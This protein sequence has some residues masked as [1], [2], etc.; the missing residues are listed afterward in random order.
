[1][2]E[3]RKHGDR[4]DRKMSVREQYEYAIEWQIATG[5][6]LK[7]YRSTRV[8]GEAKIKDAEVRRDNLYLL[9]EKGKL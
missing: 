2:A 9:I 4:K 1:M 7:A 5:E 8:L 6:I 3:K